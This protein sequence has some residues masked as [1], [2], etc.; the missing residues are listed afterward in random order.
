[1]GGTSEDILAGFHAA[2][3]VPI[4]AALLGV[5]AM[6]HRR[7]APAVAVEPAVEESL[8]EAA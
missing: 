4:G 3:F 1:V 7:P 2:L 6:L 5:V 8:E